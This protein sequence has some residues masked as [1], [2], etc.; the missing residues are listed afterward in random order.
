VDGGSEGTSAGYAGVLQVGHAQSTWV[1]G[2]L[3]S[4]THLRLGGFGA[5][6]T[7]V[8]QTTLTISRRRKGLVHPSVMQAEG[9]VLRL[10]V[11]RVETRAR[12]DEFV[13]DEHERL[14]RLC[15]S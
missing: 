7:P 4:K 13:E 5:P 8:G 12:F 2:V 3:T 6:C 11:D 1:D 15:T 9:E 14:Y 10:P